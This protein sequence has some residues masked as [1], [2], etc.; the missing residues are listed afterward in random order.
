MR[1]F[2]PNARIL[3]PPRDGPHVHVYQLTRNLIARGHEVITLEPDQNPVT[4]IRSRRPSSVLAAIRSSDVIYCRP[5]ESPT[6]AARL[7]GYPWRLMIPRRTAVVWEQNRALTSSLRPVKRTARRIDADIAEFRRLARRV[8]AGIGVAP[9]AT[10]E[11][12]SLLGIRHVYTIPN[13]SDPEMFRPGLAP[14]P[15]LKREDGHLQVGWIGSHAN[16]IHDAPL[17]EATAAIAHS[18]ALP[19]QFHVMGDTR[20][21][22]ADEAPPNMSFH[23]PVAY[24]DLP[25]YLAAM[26]VGLVLYKGSTDGGSPLKLFDYMASACVPICSPGA[27]MLDILAGEDVGYISAWTPE[28]LCA[29][30]EALHRAPEHRNRLALRARALIEERYSWKKVAERVEAVMVDALARRSRRT[31][32]WRRTPVA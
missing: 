24:Q 28:S 4:T 25:S 1:V 12:K 16:S 3:Y 7:A 18:T 26:D 13:A 19:V 10:E 29:Q 22:F 2:F 21:M 11:L 5:S 17:I 23:G 6:M 15:D 8:D 20:R 30:L 32:S 9:A 31:D 14:P 27:A